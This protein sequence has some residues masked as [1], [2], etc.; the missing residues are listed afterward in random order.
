[1]SN[2]RRNQNDGEQMTKARD[3]TFALIR[4]GHVADS[5][6][7]SVSRLIE[8]HLTDSGAFWFCIR[9]DRKYFDCCPVCKAEGKAKGLRT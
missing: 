8:S 5:A 1:M 4:A 9:H 2:L 3:I 6:F 7:T